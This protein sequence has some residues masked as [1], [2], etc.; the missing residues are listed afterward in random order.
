[1]SPG[2]EDRTG[3][4]PGEGEREGRS[5]LLLRLL[6]GLATALLILSALLC[7][8]ASIQVVTRGYVKILGFSVF[9]VVTGSMEPTI[10]VGAILLNRSADIGSVRVGDIVCYQDERSDMIITH[11]VVKTEG[12]GADRRLETR[13]DANLVSDLGLV[14]RTNLLGRVVW[15]TGKES[16]FTDMLSFLGG[17]TGFLALVV[18]PV[19]LIVSLVLQRMGKSIRREIASA[20]YAPP[21][22]EGRPDPDDLVP[23]YTTITWRDYEEIYEHLKRDLLKDLHEQLGKTDGKTE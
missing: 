18:L 15:Y 6:S 9:R 12:W 17:K 11:R 21:E 2:P 14:D 5:P 19:L 13:G 8:W 1:M 23:G 3:L 10:P 16:V 20:R 4:P 22:A 7:L